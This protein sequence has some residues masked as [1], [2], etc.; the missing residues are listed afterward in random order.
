MVRTPIAQSSFWSL[1]ADPDERDSRFPIIVQAKL[2]RLLWSYGLSAFRRIF[3]HAQA[4]DSHLNIGVIGESAE[5]AFEIAYLPLTD[6][7][8]WRK[9]R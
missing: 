6:S 8:D 7:Q 5:Y 4:D 2:I 9:W 3:H 1:V